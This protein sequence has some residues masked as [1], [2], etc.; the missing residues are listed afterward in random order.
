MRPFFSFVLYI[1]NRE[2]I[3]NEIYTPIIRSYFQ[4]YNF[5]CTLNNKNEMEKQQHT[6]SCYFIKKKKKKKIINKDSEEA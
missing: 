3:K 1:I 2:N 4:L 6:V 5:N